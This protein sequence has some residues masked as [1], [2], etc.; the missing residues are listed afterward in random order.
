MVFILHIPLCLCCKDGWMTGFFSWADPLSHQ[1]WQEGSDQCSFIV[2]GYEGEFGDSCRSA[3]NFGVLGVVCTNLQTSP[4][5]CLSNPF[6]GSEIRLS[7]CFQRAPGMGL[8]PQVLPK[9]KQQN[10]HGTT[11]LLGPFYLYTQQH[12]MPCQWWITASIQ[13]QQKQEMDKKL[14]A[15]TLGLMHMPTDKGKPKPNTS[16]KGVV[17]KQYLLQCIC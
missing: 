5:P 1:Q 6:K 15:I 13:R 7:L 2:M 17:W 4:C 14:R 3:G 12:Q 9:H 10:K 16:R 11:D 8:K